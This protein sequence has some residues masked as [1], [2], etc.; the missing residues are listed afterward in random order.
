M[1]HKPDDVNQLLAAHHVTIDHVDDG[2]FW[3]VQLVGT[4]GAE[5][6]ATIMND[7]MKPHWRRERFDQRATNVNPRVDIRDR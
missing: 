3:I 4:G 1:S 5:S 6:S 2:E 7:G